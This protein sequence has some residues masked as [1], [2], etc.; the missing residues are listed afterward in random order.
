MAIGQSVATDHYKT[1]TFDCIIFPATSN[2]LIGGERFTPTRIEI[3]K[4]EKLLNEGLKN[5]NASLLNQ[6]GSDQSPI[7]HEK[8]KKYKRQYFGYIDK[9]KSKL[10]FINC[11]WPNKRHLDNWDKQM[12]FVLDGGSYYWSIKVNLETEELFELSINGNA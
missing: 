12:I 1:K 6:N 9:N 3:Q 10:L 5:I 4:A 11:F 8:L 7:I 2:E